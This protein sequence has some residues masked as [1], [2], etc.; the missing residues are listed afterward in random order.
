MR[1]VFPIIFWYN[2]GVI[3]LK[4]VPA[5]ALITK[6]AIA[7]IL[8]AAVVLALPLNAFGEAGIHAPENASDEEIIAYAFIDGI[9]SV[10]EMGHP[11]AE[12]GLAAAAE[13]PYGTAAASISAMRCA[14]DCLLEMK[15]AAPTPGRL[16]DWDE[17]AAL[18]WASPY[19]Y[20]F[21]GIVLEAEGDEGAAT[22]CYEKAALNPAISEGD[23]HLRYIVRLDAE[24][25]QTLRSALTQVE[26]AIFAAYTPMPAAI[27]RSEHN[28]S[29]PYLRERCRAALEAGGAGEAGEPAEPDHGL[30]LQYAHAALSLE[31]FNGDNYASLAALYLAMEEPGAALRWLNEGL[32]ADPE[33]ESLNALH[34]AM[35]GVL[36]Q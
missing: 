19:P 35:E 30:A 29:A 28:F 1:L 17:I 15:G 25:L 21:E 4:G 34:Q 9:V 32:F 8:A 6:G 10:F 31:P 12:A 27:P 2:A 3:I 22:S 18:G 26:D 23:R 33:S 7:A 5:M 36:G 13:Y 16:S 24:Q 20:V 14:V 11:Y